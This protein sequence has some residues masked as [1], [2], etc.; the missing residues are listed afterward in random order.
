MRVRNPQRPRK[1]TLKWL[2]YIPE[3]NMQYCFIR[4]MAVWAK[5]EAETDF[6][7]TETSSHVLYCPQIVSPARALRGNPL[8]LESQNWLFL[9]QMLRWCD[10]QM[11]FTAAIKNLLISIMS[12]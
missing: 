6:F 1:E 9:T 10:K 11:Y 8:I 7:L 12:P 5:N 2:S 4:L 3:T